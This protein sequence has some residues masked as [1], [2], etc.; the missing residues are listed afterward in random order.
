MTAIWMGILV[1][2]AG[3]ADVAD[4]IPQAASA[5]RA[6]ADEVRAQGWIAYAARSDK[7]D[8]DIFACRPDGSQIRNL[9]GTPEHNEFS[10]QFSRDG[11][12]LLYRRMPRTETIDNNHYGTQGEL[13]LANADGTQPQVFGAE[14][15]YAWTSWSPNGEQL[16]C[17]SIKGITFIDVATQQVVR[18]WRAVMRTTSGLASPGRLALGVETAA[19]GRAFSQARPSPRRPAIRAAA[20]FRWGSRRRPGRSGPEE[21]RQDRA[22]R[23]LRA[24]SLALRALV[25]RC[26]AGNRSA[27][28][29]VPAGRRPSPARV[30]ARSRWDAGRKG[31]P[32]TTSCPVSLIRLSNSSL[33]A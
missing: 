17:L 16:A 24:H 1:L 3:A 15:G 28:G 23:V 20:A 5:D 4:A 8:W 33:P 32:A 31:S 2:A 21:P 14:G 9:T 13:V 26:V 30:S 19:T 6:L 18:K 11:R 7:G 29:E 22:G 25:G 27:A 12:R 10:P